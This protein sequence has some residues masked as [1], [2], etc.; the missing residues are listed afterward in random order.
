MKFLFFAAK[1]MDLKGIMQSEISQTE[2][3]QILYNI[4]YMWNPKIQQA[5]E[6]SKNKNRLMHRQK[7]LVITS[8][9]GGQYR[10]RDWEGHTTRFKI[11]YKGI[12]YYIVKYIGEYSQYSVITVNRV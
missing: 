4:T 5:S 9:R 7:K 6:N 12:F 8:W 3:G 2:K 10:G 11:D 1:W